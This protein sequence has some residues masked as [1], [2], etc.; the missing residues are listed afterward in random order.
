MKIV[1]LQ[2]LSKHIN[3]IYCIHWVMI[4]IACIVREFTWKNGTFG[5]I[6]ATIVAATFLIAS[7]WLADLYTKMKKTRSD[8]LCKKH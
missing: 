4:G 2:K 7:E 6:P 8:W 5:M 1:Y 3:N